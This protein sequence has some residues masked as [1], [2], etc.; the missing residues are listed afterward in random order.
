MAIAVAPTRP[1]ISLRAAAVVAGLAYLLDPVS[2]AEFTLYPKLV[3]P[4]NIDQTVA[5][6][7]AN[8]ETFAAIIGCYLINFAEDVVM[9]WALYVLLGPVNRPLA[10]LMAWFQLIYTAV[11]LFGVTNLTT[12]YHL[13]TTPDYLTL[14][15][16]G[17]LHAQVFL[18]LHAFRYDWSLS[19]I[20]FGIHLCLLGYLV[21]RARYIPWILGIVLAINGAGWIVDGLQPYLYPDAKLDFVFYTYFGEVIWMLWLLIRGWA[22]KEPV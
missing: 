4:G 2:Y 14:F 9:A 15:G 22:I 16:T 10:L 12:V 8:H 3:I 17:Q 1:D 5:N 21:F 18:L 6:I 20:F 19:L 7:A 11:A 13:L